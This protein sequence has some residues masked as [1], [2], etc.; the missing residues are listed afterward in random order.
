MTK[1]NPTPEVADD[2][3][4]SDGITEYDYR[5]V[6]TYIRFL[7][8]DN[9]VLGKDEMARLILGIDPA[10]APERPRKAVE[11]HLARARWTTEVGYCHLAASATRVPSSTRPRCSNR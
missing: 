5:H 2:V 8:A 9:E 7:D 11:S 3:P 4:W 10:N 1:P 6:E